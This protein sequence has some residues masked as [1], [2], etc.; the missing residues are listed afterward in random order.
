MK[1]I[2]ILLISLI[3]TSVNAASIIFYDSKKT[4]DVEFYTI[5]TK[6]VVKINYDESEKEIH[7]IYTNGGGNTFIVATSNEA[8]EI[9]K[10][11]YD[12]TDSSFIELERS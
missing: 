9:I 4:G 5:N 7:V 11:L 2:F 3:A 10:R 12:E 6:Q 8:I 1:V